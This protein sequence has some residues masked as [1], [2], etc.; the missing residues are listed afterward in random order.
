M[1]TVIKLNGEKE[2]YSESKIKR[3]LMN[4]GATK[5]QAR[6]IAAKVR[7]ILY[8][9]ITTKEIFRY[10]FREYKKIE[11]VMG[12]K[13][14]LKNS[15]LQ[16]GESGFPFEAFIERILIAEGY[17]C[18]RNLIVKGKI[19]THEI[20]V[21]AKKGKEVL[22]VECKHHSK[23]WVGEN[24]QTAL[25]VYARFLDVKKR[26]TRPMLATN[27]KFS[28]QVIDYSRGVGLKLLGWKYPRG[29]SL[30]KK[31]EKFKLFPITTI[32]LK[33]FVLEACLK[34]D[35]ILLQDLRKYTPKK[36]SRLFRISKTQAE[37]IVKKASKICELNSH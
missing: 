12:C 11:P 28:K 2:K 34:N 13:F 19:I 18:K 6:E 3:S 36:L 23:P 25:Y 29:E 14:N 27:T 24:I 31:I 32:P 8:N 21:T 30:E 10:A 20:D 15:I 33:R 5:K 35:I 37:N 17:S 26:F 9:N 16:L 1:I 7:R 4:A 22:M